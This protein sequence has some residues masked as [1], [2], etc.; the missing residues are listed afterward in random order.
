MIPRLAA[1]ILEVDQ[2]ESAAFT[3]ALETLERMLIRDADELLKAHGVRDGA[4]TADAWG[5]PGTVTRFLSSERRRQNRITPWSW[6]AWHDV[7]QRAREG[8]RPLNI[9]VS[10][11]FIGESGVPVGI[12]SL[13]LAVR[14]RS[15]QGCLMTVRLTEDLLAPSMLTAPSWGRLLAN[16][17]EQARA[18]VGFFAWVTTNE[19]PIL[20][21]VALA[22]ARQPWQ[23]NLTDYDARLV[24][25]GSSVYSD[26][27]QGSEKWDVVYGETTAPT[28]AV[29]LSR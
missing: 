15:R 2:G 24:R 19:H 18:D 28:V 27:A 23:D 22:E 4:F 5:E 16:L 25:V 8:R 7:V 17:G 10:W 1:L 12:F 9:D 26:A 21:A 13:A 29:L 20:D 11:L 6:S 3:R 14:L